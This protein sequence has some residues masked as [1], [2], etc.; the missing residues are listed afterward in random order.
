MLVV[1]YVKHSDKEKWPIHVL[2]NQWFSTLLLWSGA[3]LQLHLDDFPAAIPAECVETIFPDELS[4]YQPQKD[5]EKVNILPR[6]II[7][8]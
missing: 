8:V 6:L 1:N 5:V 4:L 2:F 7:S 3:A